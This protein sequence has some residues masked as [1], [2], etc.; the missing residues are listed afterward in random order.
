MLSWSGIVE[1]EEVNFRC[2]LKMEFMGLADGF[3]M[4]VKRRGGRG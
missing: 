2:I 3:K 1:E 4:E